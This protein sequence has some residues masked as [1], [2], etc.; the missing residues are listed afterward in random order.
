MDENIDPI[1]KTFDLSPSAGKL[2]LISKIDWEAGY[3]RSRLR[4]PHYRLGRAGV[5]NFAGGK[6]Q[7]SPEARKVDCKCPAKIPAGARDQDFFS[8]EGQRIFH[9]HAATTA[10]C[11]AL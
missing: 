11:F 5:L 4:A 9:Y 3:V 8:G 2:P 6:Q 10:P 7:V 1:R